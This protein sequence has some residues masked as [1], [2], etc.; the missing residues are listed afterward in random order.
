LVLADAAAIKVRM[1]TTQAMYELFV[2]AV[3]K[4]AVDEAK[5]K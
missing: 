5:W 3:E 2:K 4:A 1:L